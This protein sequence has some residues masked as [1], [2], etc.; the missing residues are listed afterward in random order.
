[1]TLGGG[2]GGAFSSVSVVSESHTY[3]WMGIGKKVTIFCLNKCPSR[4]SP[5]CFMECKSEKRKLHKK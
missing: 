1:M 4:Y 2:G 5:H 3:D